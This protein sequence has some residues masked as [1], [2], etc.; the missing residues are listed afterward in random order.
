MFPIIIIPAY[1]PSDSLLSLLASITALDEEINILLVDDGSGE[2]YAALFG[3]ATK[4]CSKVLTHEQ[5][6][7][8]GDALK[9]AFQ[10]VLTHYPESSG[11]V[12]VDAD[13]QHAPTDVIKLINKFNRAPNKLYLGV[14]SFTN[15]KIPWRS[16][17]GNKMT[18]FIF[19]LLCKK[20]ITDTQTGLRAIPRALITEMLDSTAHRYEFELEMLIKAI[21]LKVTI[22]EIAIQTLYFDNNESS[23]FNP[24][25]DSLRIYFVFIRFFAT[26]LLS[27]G[28]EY[29]LFFSLF[30]N[31]NNIAISL[32]SS[33]F[34]SGIFN[35]NMNK[36]RVFI[37]NSKNP[38]S[39][40]QYVCLTLFLLLIN[41][42]LVKNLFA[43]SD[44]IVLSKIL[45]EILT[46]SISFSVQ[47]FFIFK[48]KKQLKQ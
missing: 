21:D 22:K 18:R 17:I 15:K 24:L 8:K 12:T 41:Y 25:I 31:L 11:V 27:A 19:R 7:G 32:V 26:S 47:H 40:I 34:L 3:Q 20:Q 28:I 23:H 39:L 30:F 35:F 44:N 48:S 36:K 2:Q 9:T 37:H 46:F 16:Q 1:Q 33:K 29:I 43:V 38:K 10:Y 45:A 42:N 14:R 13:G 4:Y 5:N 6:L